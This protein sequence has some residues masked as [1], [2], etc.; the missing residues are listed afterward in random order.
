ML[1]RLPFL[2]LLT[3]ASALAACD[4][5]VLV[6]RNPKDGD[7]DTPA[8]EPTEARQAD[9]YTA[10][11]P[12]LELGFY[13]SYTI[14]PGSNPRTAAIV[15]LPDGRFAI[16]WAEGGDDDYPFQGIYFTVGTRDVWSEPT[17]IEGSASWIVDELLLFEHE[18]QLTL[19]AAGDAPVLAQGTV[20]GFTGFQTIPGGTAAQHPDGTVYILDEAGQAIRRLDGGTL[21]PS[22]VPLPPAAIH[23]CAG[24]PVDF[25]FRS[26]GAVVVMVSDCPTSALH[27]TFEGVLTYEDGAWSAPTYLD[28]RALR[29]RDGT[30]SVVG[31]SMYLDTDQG[32][33]F[34][35]T[36]SADGAA[37][38]PTRAP[39]V[40]IDP[41]ER[42]HVGGAF[43][44]DGGATWEEIAAPFSP[45]DIGDLVGAFEQPIG[46][47]V[48]TDG[49]NVFWFEPTPGSDWP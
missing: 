3:S 40:E 2:V 30:S 14:V 8:E 49:R 39:L 24:V 6:D 46:R 11:S 28:A 16:A 34:Y 9:K 20:D 33:R 15:S 23:G 27:G 17:L 22:E 12:G 4:S 31:V 1:R 21:V 44:E 10:S 26:E 41:W 5:T 18:G 13:S 38:Y 47:P 7:D 25:V 42:A 29:P 32:G 45:G 48:F 43:S 37:Q 19:H 36:Q 35:F